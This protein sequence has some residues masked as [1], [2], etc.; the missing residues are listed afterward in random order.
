MRPKRSGL[1]AIAGLALTVIFG[2]AEAGASTI[3]VDMTIFYFP[4]PTGTLSQ[5]SLTG[6]TFFRNSDDLTLFTNTIGPLSAG[7]SEDPG[8][9]TCTGA[10][11]PTPSKALVAF[12]N[13]SFDGTIGS[14]V[15]AFA[16]QNLAAVPSSPPTSIPLI[17]IDLVPGTDLT[18]PIFAF[19]GPVQVGTWEVTVT[20]N[21]VP[22]P[23]A[24]AGLPG[25][26]LACGGLLGWWRRKRKAFAALV[27]A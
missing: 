8:W 3:L 24:G 16:F 14:N 4:V 10:S 9:S 13:V 23:I 11:C 12:A 15:P 26:M 27:V 25:L 2:T 20:A 17:P 6:T 7:Q 19:D 22:G 5:Y 18:G 1:T 21:G